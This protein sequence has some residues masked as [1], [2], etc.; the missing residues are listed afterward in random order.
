MPGTAN[1]RSGGATSAASFGRRLWL[2]R[3]TVQRFRNLRQAELLLEPGPVVLLGE[4]GAGKTNILEAISLLTPGRGLRRSRLVELEPRIP[5]NAAPEATGWAVAAR[6]ETPWG[7]HDIGTGS[8]PQSGSG[9]ERR[10]VKVDGDYA[11]SQTALGEVLAAVWVSP[12]MDSL[13]REGASERRR[14]LDRLVYAFDPAHAGRLNAY[15]RA[16][17]ERSRLLR[18]GRGEPEWLAALE[19]TMAEKAVAIAAGRREM[20]GRLVGACAESLG[21][22]PRA[23]LA[24]SGDAELWLDEAPALAVE[25]RLQ[26]SLRE[27]RTRDGEIGGAGVG[28][29]RCDLLVHHGDHG[30]PAEICSTGEQKALL[31]TIVLGHARLMTLERGA[32]PLLLLDEVAAHLDARR[33]A[34]LYDEI[35][36]LGL[37]AWFSGTDPRA[38]EPLGEAAQRFRLHEGLLLKEG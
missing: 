20:V 7:P 19:R 31:L 21:P 17:R 10:L 30:R 13:F 29:H 33:L 2:S 11:A 1:G 8:D 27:A 14:F 36:G 22:F 4:N 6:V 37:Q 28:A 18:E 38:F 24:L 3:L 15:D 32:A 5:G 23:G 12:E 35:L 16:M 9:R 25:E 26:Q 34:A